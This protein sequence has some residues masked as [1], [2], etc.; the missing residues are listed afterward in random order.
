[1]LSRR[2]CSSL[3]PGGHG[4]P[5]L[6]EPPDQTASAT[7]PRCRD[8]AV[9]SWPAATT[10]VLAQ[11]VPAEN[12]NRANNPPA[13]VVPAAPGLPG[14]IGGQSAQVDQQDQHF[15]RAAA[16]GNLAEIQAG[17]VAMHKGHTQAVR[18]FGRWM[19]TDHTL[20]GE[21][22]KM[23]LRGTGFTPPESVNSEQ[24]QMLTHLRS[25]SGA[26]FDQQYINGIVKTIN[27]TY[28]HEVERA[29]RSRRAL[30]VTRTVAPVSA[31]T[32]PG[33]PVTPTRVVA[34]NTSFI[35][36]ATVTF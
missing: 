19:V 23:S 36:S 28:L 16:M 2:D 6:T 33:N 11:P 34:R 3:L 20:M 26:Q 12:M 8:C 5:S 27:R 13:A 31:S 24:Q 14:S 25:L 7:P 1:M 15:R 9:R 21:L 35:P 29:R 22:M 17:Q 18:E 10:P 32:A 4:E 30:S